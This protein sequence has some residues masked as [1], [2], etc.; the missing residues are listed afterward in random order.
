MQQQEYMMLINLQQP[1]SIINQNEGGQFD[2]IVSSQIKQILEK[3][4]FYSETQDQKEFKKQIVENLRNLVKKWIKDIAV[5]TP[6]LNQD[7]L[8]KVGGDLRVFGSFTLDVN[9]QESDIDTVCIAPKF[10]SREEHFFKGFYE[11][12]RN[13]DNITDIFC[14]SEALVPLIRLKY[15]NI[16]F[17]ILF[18]QINEDYIENQIDLD[19]NRLLSQ[20]DEK[21]YRSFNGLRVAQFL[22]KNIKNPNFLSALKVIKLWAKNKGI[23]SNIIGYL[24]GIGWTILLAKICQL[25]PNAHLNILIERFFFIYHQWKWQEMP[26]QIENIQSE[27]EY[28]IS[29]DQWDPT[30][31]S[32]MMVITPCF[33]CMNAAHNVSKTTLKIIQK[34]FAKAYKKVQQIRVETINYLQQIPNNQLLSSDIV[35][36]FYNQLDSLQDKYKALLQKSEFFVHYKQFIQIIVL[37][38]NQVDF[39]IWQGHVESKI[40]KL[41]HLFE[42]DMYYSTGSNNSKIDVHPYPFP[43]EGNEPNFKHSC[44]YF[45]G[46]KLNQSEQNL[47]DIQIVD[48]KQP[49]N[50]FLVMLQNSY[51]QI[52]PE[53]MT[54]NIRQVT[55]Q[56]IKDIVTQNIDKYRKFINSRTQYSNKQIL[57]SLIQNYQQV[58]EER[59]QQKQ[60][61]SYKNHGNNNNSNQQIN[62]Q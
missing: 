55:R 11:I 45:F 9:S 25:Y 30:K 51:K 8:D 13:T 35:K 59:Q 53:T 15:H 26:I 34:Q 62:Q 2:E 49:V 17:D 28:Y 57:D 12:L 38:Q 40:R 46:I 44:S 1:H 7:K 60:Q 50:D 39:N 47:D 3:Q 36:K 18:C 61:N 19:S 4:F 42:S 41:T 24:S 23:Y 10:V 56:Q 43:L 33:P 52:V 32:N 37:A 21:S 48:I 31:K 22:K 27:P 14:I 16:Q 6:Y 20:M 58:E 29:F 5:Q 54:L